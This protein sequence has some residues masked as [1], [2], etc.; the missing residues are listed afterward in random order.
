MHSPSRWNPNADLIRVVAMSMVIMLHTVLSFSVRPD[1]FGTK[2][3]VITE[4]IS[5]CSKTSVLLFFIL[6]G[7]LVI[8]KQT[9]SKKNTYNTLKKI[10]LP[11]GFFGLINYVLAYVSNPYPSFASFS[12]AQLSSLLVFPSSSLWFLV[13]LVPLYLANPIWRKLYTTEKTKRQAQLLTFAF[14]MLSLSVIII[15]QYEPTIV[16]N[17]LTA[18]LG[19]AF[20]YLYGG[21]VK[22]GWVAIHTKL[23]S[24]MLI[25]LGF[26]TTLWGDYHTLWN[27]THGVESLWNNYTAEY[28]SI[29][30]VLLA[31]GIFHLLLVLKIPEKYHNILQFFARNSFGIYLIHIYVVSFLNNAGFRFDVLKINIYL[32][33][34]LTVLLVFGISLAL[35][36]LIRKI[37]KMSALIGG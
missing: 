29:P 25:T 23:A 4:I 28:L 22:K 24:I 8:D 35:V 18:W 36:V 37:P 30:V 32:Y 15:K 34:L 12:A 3:Y 10:V 21:L 14:L 17:N 7:Y 27:T 19:F 2:I 13:V 33:N 31:M 6:S 5:A 16:L 11:L 26:F 9:S 20:F 1:F